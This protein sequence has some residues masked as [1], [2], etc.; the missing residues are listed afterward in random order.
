MSAPSPRPVPPVPAGEP[1]PRWSVMIPSHEC[2]RYLGATLRGVL[3]QDPGPEHMQI[4]VVDDHSLR[5]DLATLVREVGGGRVA[6]HRQP[7]N[8]GHI[9]NFQTCLERARGHHVHLLHGDDLVLPGFYA[10]L[11]QGLARPEVGAAFCRHRHIDSDDRELYVSPPLR[12]TAGPL[13]GWL[14]RIAVRQ[15]LQTPSIAVK[16]SVYEQL[17]GFHP[18]L[19]WVEDW[20]MW[21]RISSRHAVWFEPAVLAAYRRHGASSTAR[22]QLSAEDARDRRRAIALIARHLP[23]D[24]RARLV[25]EASR[26]SAAWC[27]E[28]ASELAAAGHRRAAWRQIA[29]ALRA[30][31]SPSTLVALARLGLRRLRA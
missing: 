7:R 28:V 17:G 3:A 29:Q 1:R 23:S 26:A 11:D 19:R 30:S 25:R 24:R 22:H 20:E 2:A 5:D 8:V 9:A 15:Q 18:S 31:P 14:E 10:A 16:R 13:E 27:V 6:Y 4:E 12:E 21:T